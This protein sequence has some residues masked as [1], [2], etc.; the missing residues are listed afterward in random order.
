MPGNPH[1]KRFL[2]LLETE[3][4]ALRHGDLA[5]LD[6]LGPKKDAVAARIDIDALDRQDAVAL[7]RAT[8]RNQTLL[9]SA[10]AGLLAA[11]ERL[12]TI[13]AGAPTRTYSA[14]GARHDITA[15]RTTIQK[16]A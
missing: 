13:R 16:R 3:R 7:A 8:A 14:R 1:V 2:A 5:M 9:E 6:K 12:A 11:R 15:G 4:A 10:K